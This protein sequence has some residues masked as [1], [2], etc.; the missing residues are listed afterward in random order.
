MPDE[1]QL[2]QNYP[3]PFNPVT[4]I[5]F[6]LPQDSKVKLLV[7]DILGREIKRLVNNEFRTAGIYS[8]EFNGTGLSSGVYFYKI[9]AGDFRQVNRMVMVK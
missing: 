7:S 2:S 6:S 4:K 3:N 5:N 8:M 1:Y 9:E